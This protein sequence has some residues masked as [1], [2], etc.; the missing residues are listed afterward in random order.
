MIC[1][2][3]HPFLL[4]NEAIENIYFPMSNWENLFFTEIKDLVLLGNTNQKVGGSKTVPFWYGEYG[5][6]APD[7][8]DRVT[9]S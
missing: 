3:D 1:D 6:K 4:P 8:L 5:S 2:I 7:I 9:A